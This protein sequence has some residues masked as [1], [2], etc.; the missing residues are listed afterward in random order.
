MIILRKGHNKNITRQK[1]KNKTGS[2]PKF[3]SQQAPHQS[4]NSPTES[5]FQ[6]QR[7]LSVLNQMLEVRNSN[8]YYNSYH[9]I[10]AI[11]N[12]RS[13]VLS[14][15]YLWPTDAKLIFYVWLS[16]MWL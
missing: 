8:H 6:F 4:S 9:H 14:I 10:R 13:K 3:P 5:C 2:P 12:A 7:K 16:I 1:K 15:S 11:D